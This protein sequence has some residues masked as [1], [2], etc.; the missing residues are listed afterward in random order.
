MDDGR[1]SIELP[2]GASYTLD[3]QS[4]ILRR[5]EHIERFHEYEKAQ[6]KQAKKAA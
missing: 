3:P 1:G 2:E 4:K 5:D 6:R